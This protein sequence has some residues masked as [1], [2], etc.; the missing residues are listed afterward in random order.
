MCGR[1]FVEPREGMMDLG[2][3]IAHILQREEAIVKQ[4]KIGEIF[5]TNIAPILTMDQ[6][7]NAAAPANEMGVLHA[8]TA[9]VWLSTRAAKRR[10]KNG[11]FKTA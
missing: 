2:D 3:L 4:M 11:C 9:R 1:Y 6:G 8:M 10:W 5:P 7:R